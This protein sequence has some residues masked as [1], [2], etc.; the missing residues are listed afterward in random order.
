MNLCGCRLRRPTRPELRCAFKFCDK[1]APIATSE[2]LN[3]FAKFN[4][5][6]CGSL[7]DTAWLLHMPY[8]DVAVNFDRIASIRR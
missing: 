2:D 5:R 8:P 3:E 4:C 7:A 6:D 1:P